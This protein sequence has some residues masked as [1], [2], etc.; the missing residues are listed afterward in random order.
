MRFPL[1][2]FAS[3]LI[4]CQQK[5]PTDLK[6]VN[7]DLGLNEVSG[8]TWDERQ[9]LFYAIQ[10]SGNG[11]FLFGLDE[12]GNQKHKWT[13]NAKNTDWEEITS[14]K[15]GKI[16]IGDFGNNKNK[17][18]DLAIYAIDSGK[19]NGNDLITPLY[20]ITFNFQQQRSFPPQK[21]RLL[22]DCEA[23]V[24]LGDCFYL[25]TK[26]RSKQFDGTSLV[27]KIKNAP[28]HQT[29]VLLGSFRSCDNFNHCAITGAAISPDGQKIV[30]LSH[31]KLFVFENFTADSF[32]EVP[33]KT[34]E[35]HHFSQKEAICFKGSDTLVLAD[36]K[37]RGNGGQLYSIPLSKLKPKT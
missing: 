9:D 20:Q 3:L 16:Y 30:L 37:E 23:F 26:N 35:L 33:M 29:A 36:E 13:V 1:L 7:D 21:T 4:G 25:F 18:K 31:S 32:L 12:N 8:I 11:S 2:F 34:Y 24:V 10:D 6:V 28:G 22:Y 27:Y 19:I 15:S 5:Q 14:D 17:R